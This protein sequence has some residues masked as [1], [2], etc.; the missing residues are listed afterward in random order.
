MGP[1]GK[2]SAGSPWRGDD[3]VLR[4]RSSGSQGSVSGSPGR[5]QENVSRDS[6]I[7]GLKVGKNI[8]IN[9]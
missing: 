4:E 6:G 9:F 1:Q 2:V 8:K 7:G 5:L 3:L